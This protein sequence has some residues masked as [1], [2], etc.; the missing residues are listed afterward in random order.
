[1]AWSMNI[2]N[3]HFISNVLVGIETTYR[4][5][6]SWP[7]LIF[8]VKLCLRNISARS[9]CKSSHFIEHW[10]HYMTLITKSMLYMFYLQMAIY[11]SLR[12]PHFCLWDIYVSVMCWKPH[13]YISFIVW[14]SKN[15]N[16]THSIPYQKLPVC[17]SIYLTLYI[18]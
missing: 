17:Q 15:P 9:D 7:L 2:L 8:Y 16:F 4:I 5:N 18:Q 12:N 1:M 6:L 11:L 10:F 3:S 14:I 13:L